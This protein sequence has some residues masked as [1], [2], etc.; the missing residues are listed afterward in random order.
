MKNWIEISER[1]LTTNY[2]TLVQSAGTAVSVLAVIK[3]DAYGHGAALCAPVLARAGATWLGV[4][5]AK[6]GVQI[7]EEFAHEKIVDTP[8]ILIMSGSLPEE[9][10]MIVLRDL[11]PV[12]WS[13][14]ELE[15]LAAEAKAQQKQLPVHVEID[16]GMS[17]QGCAVGDE[18]QSI[19][20]WF[21]AQNALTLDGIMTHFSS[22]EIA[23][24]PISTEQRQAF[25]QAIAQIKASGLQ[26]QWVHAG[27]SSAVDNLHPFATPNAAVATTDCHSERSAKRAVEEPPH[28][29]RSATEATAPTSLEWLVQQAATLN[30]KA[31]VRTGL[32]LYGHCLPVESASGY[33][34]PHEASV[35]SRLLPVLTWKARVIG[36]RDIAAGTHVGYGATFTAPHPMRLAL[37]PV[38]YADG[39][40]RELSSSPT[41]AGWVMLHGQRASIVGRV[42]MNLTVVDITHIAAVAIGDEAIILGE[43]ITAED[44]ARIAGTISYEILCGMKSHTL[45]S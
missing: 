36:L 13:I 37:L 23:G 20:N 19:L 16:T 31:M 44:H 34:G 7:Q 11:T 14:E 32:A 2:K 6:E 43:G 30:A 33:T 1:R 8:R 35:Q 45:L 29:A 5:D 10:R 3:A 42:S 26:P 15:A 25:E 39:L 18:L 27:N 22:A 40:R 12:V 4:T 41:G 38:G 17:R 28:S 9:A 24:S 21:T